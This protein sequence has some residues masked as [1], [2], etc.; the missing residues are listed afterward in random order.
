MAL[1]G[2]VTIEVEFLVNAHT[3]TAVAMLDEQADPIYAQMLGARNVGMVF[4]GSNENPAMRAHGR[5][6]MVFEGYA[7]RS[8]DDVP[9]DGIGLQIAVGRALQQ[10]ADYY[11]AN[12]EGL[13]DTHNA[14]DED[15][16]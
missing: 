15:E 3:A 8:R 16:E 2:R 13:L 10:A 5:S 11:L 9:N 6:M 7:T 4:N 14:E 1:K 12:V